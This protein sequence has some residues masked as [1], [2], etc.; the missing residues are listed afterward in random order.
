MQESR[1]S[2]T[3]KRGR[4][5]CVC[6]LDENLWGSPGGDLVPALDTEGRER[7]K[8]VA[9]YSQVVGGTFSK[10]GYLQRRLVLGAYRMSWSLYQPS[11]NLKSLYRRLN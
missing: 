9:D 5:L 3:W 2:Q 1:L 6:V 7:L 10:E 8:K 4:W 11:Q